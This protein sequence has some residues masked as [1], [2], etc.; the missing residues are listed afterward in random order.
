MLILDLN[1]VMISNLMVSL[2]REPDVN[3]DLVRHMILNSIRM[4]RQKFAAE[5]G[6]LII[7]CDDKNYW[8]KDIFPY[9]KAHR[10]EDR[11]KSTHDWNKIFECLNKIRDELKQYFPYKTIQV[12][13]AEADD[14]I[15]VLTRKFGVYLNNKSTE[16]V[17]ILSGDKDFGQLQ[18]YLN[19]DQYSP[20]LKKWIRIQD[21]HRFL[22]EHI[23]KGDR[24][25]G[26]PNFLSEDSTIISKKRQKPLA[27]KK[28]DAWIDLEPEKFCDDQMLKNYRRNEALVD[29]EQVPDEVSE[30]ILEQY[31]NCKPAKRS[32]LLN[33]FIKNKL[34]NL[35]DVIGEF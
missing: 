14:I 23:M 1:Q 20:V 16:K 15:G 19:V 8:R 6:E 25:D 12:E 2:N 5:Y 34:K 17:L 3:E 21:P 26:I 29:L 31:E 18:K 27:S 4:Y 30:K 10:K 7:A 11:S 33:Y 35:M 22:R 24:G 9:Y 13:R 28:L 32:G